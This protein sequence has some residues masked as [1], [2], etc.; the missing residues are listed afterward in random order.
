MFRRPVPVG[1]VVDITSDSDFPSRLTAPMQLKVSQ[2]QFFFCNPV[3]NFN[4]QFR[5]R[6][7]EEREDSDRDRPPPDFDS[8]EDEHGNLR[9]FVVSDDDILD[10][11]P[12][13]KSK[14][15]RIV[16]SSGY[17]PHFYFSFCQLT[18]RFSDLKDCQIQITT[19]SARNRI[20][21][22]AAITISAT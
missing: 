10:K 3:L 1:D 4:R 18:L 11:P 12:S 15:P 16:D 21:P 19:T 13:R 8:D 22:H 2:V 5:G 20:V 14:Q 7:E 17:A 6:V 9:G